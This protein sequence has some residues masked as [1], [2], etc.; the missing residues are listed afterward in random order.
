MSFTLHLRPSQASPGQPCPQS[1][2]IRAVPSLGSHTHSAQG[3]SRGQVCRDIKDSP[4]I[5]AHLGGQG[6]IAQLSHRLAVRNGRSCIL[7]ISKGDNFGE[8]GL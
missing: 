6:V 8:P 3:C 5:K 4:G 7:L 1:G 2:D